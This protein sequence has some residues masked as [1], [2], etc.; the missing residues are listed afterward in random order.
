MKLTS[1]SGNI[2]SNSQNFHVHDPLST[3]AHGACSGEAALQDFSK[4]NKISVYVLTF[5]NHLHRKILSAI[6]Q[7]LEIKKNCNVHTRQTYRIEVEEE[8]GENE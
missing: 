1:L 3:S 4:D 7:G 2:E 5:S 6:F 8:R